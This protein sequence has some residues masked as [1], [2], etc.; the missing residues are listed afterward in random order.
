MKVFLVFSELESISTEPEDEHGEAGKK[1]K[2]EENG[3]EKGEEDRPEE[4]EDGE[5]EEEQTMEEVEGNPSSKPNEE[6]TTARSPKDQ[7]ENPQKEKDPSQS[8]SRPNKK[9]LPITGENQAQNGGDGKGMGYVKSAENIDGEIAQEAGV[10]GVDGTKFKDYSAMFLV[11]LP[12]TGDLQAHNGAN[13]KGMKRC[14]SAKNT[15]NDTVQDASST[16]NNTTRFK[17]CS[18]M[19]LVESQ[20]NVDRK[21]GAGQECLKDKSPTGCPNMKGNVGCSKEKGT[22][23]CSRCEVP[24]GWSKDTARKG[25]SSMLEEK[26]SVEI[27]IMN[28]MDHTDEEG[29][30]NRDFNE[31]NIE[32]GLIKKDDVAVKVL[33]YSNMAFN[34]EEEEC[35]TF[36][37]Q[38]NQSDISQSNNSG[39]ESDRGSPTLSVGNN[40]NQGTKIKIV[41][42]KASAQL[43]NVAGSEVGEKT[44]I[45]NEVINKG[46]EILRAESAAGPADH[47]FIV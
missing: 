27:E 5:V 3:E 21:E 12:N 16:G 11:E 22:S 35:D 29:H 20:K 15:E 46:M 45:I 8:V 28:K 42:Q 19:F 36:K 10:T 26:D 23:G 47:K 40:M 7:L 2:Q 13:E 9:E 32:R 43:E 14:K 6:Q 1:N 25:Q 33:S 17:D 4:D 18:A 38:Y 30:E 41:D 31:D 39:H 44:L 34:M 37:D 24:I